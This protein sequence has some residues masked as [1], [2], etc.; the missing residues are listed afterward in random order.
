[1][2]RLSAIPELSAD[3]GTTIESLLEADD[4]EMLRA[5]NRIQDKIRG[6]VTDG[7]ENESREKFR[8]SQIISFVEKDK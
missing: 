3:I 1:M 4:A 8:P 7:D 5:I 2:K 6:I